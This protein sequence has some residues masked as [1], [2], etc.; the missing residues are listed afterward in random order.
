[1]SHKACGKSCEKPKNK[2]IE[3]QVL[4]IWSQI[5]SQFLLLSYREWNFS[6]EAGIEK[7]Y[8]ELNPGL[9][10]GFSCQCSTTELRP[11]NSFNCNSVVEHWW[12]KPGRT[13]SSFLAAANFS[14]FSHLAT[15]INKHI[16]ISSWSK[17]LEKGNIFL[18][19]NL[20][21]YIATFT[22][23]TSVNLV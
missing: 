9:L 1:M 17:R 12:L 11:S 4:I 10:H 20:L 18:I 2:S 23:T 8:Q 14:Q 19:I 3:F 5:D 13:L 16:F 6:N 15:N 7:V 21:A 22:Q